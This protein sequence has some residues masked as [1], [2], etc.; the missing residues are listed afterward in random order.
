MTR[1]RCRWDGWKRRRWL[2]GCEEVLIS[3]SHSLREGGRS[4]SGRAA[5][6]A[7]MRHIW[8]AMDSDWRWATPSAGL[9]RL[10]QAQVLMPSPIGLPSPVDQARPTR[11]WASHTGDETT[12]PLGSP[13]ARLRYL[14]IVAPGVSAEH[15]YGVVLPCLLVSQPSACE[16]RAVCRNRTSSWHMAVGMGC[17]AGASASRGL[18]G[19]V[20][21]RV[22]SAGSPPLSFRVLE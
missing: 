1:R 11:P 19:V 9:P 13:D 8:L 18:L 12:P 3:G 2:E 10:R 21:G 16:G 17:S 6:G 4:I 5:W 20:S 22:L 15:P 14:A 7:S